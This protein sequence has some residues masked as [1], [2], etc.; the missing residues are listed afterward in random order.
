MRELRNARH[1]GPIAVRV[2]HGAHQHGARALGQRVDFVHLD[3]F[4]AAVRQRCREVILIGKFVAQRDDAISRVPVHAAEE[5]RERRRGIHGERDVVGLA[6]DQLRDER[7]DFVHIVE[8]GE[9]VGAGGFIAPREVPVDGGA[10]ARGT[11]PKSR[12][13]A[14]SSFRAPETQREWLA[15]FISRPD[16]RGK[17]FVDR[18]AEFTDHVATGTSRDVRLLRVDQFHQRLARASCRW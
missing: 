6:V 2:I 11:C 17:L 14:T 8:P 12:Y 9:E 5:Q 10:G 15:Q 7:A 4:H 1:V 3:Q 13:S 18:L 16:R